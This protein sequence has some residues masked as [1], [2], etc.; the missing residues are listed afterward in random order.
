MVLRWYID[1]NI[2][3]AKTEV[4]GVYTLDANYVPVAVDISVR[5]PG[6]GESMILDINDDGTSIFTYRPSLTE[7]QTEH[8]WTTIP[9]NVMRK[10]SKVT[11]DI[12]SVFG[13][14][15]ARDLTVELLLEEA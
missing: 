3:R 10:G 7:N 6:T 4:G 5:V 9:E 14:D 12:D 8:R 13:T 11:L 2:A 1:G 15:T